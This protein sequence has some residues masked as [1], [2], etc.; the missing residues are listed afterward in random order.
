[1]NPRARQIP[2][3][4]VTASRVP[5]AAAAAVLLVRGRMSG[6]EPWVVLCLLALI[7]AT[8]VFDGILARRLGVAGLFG[9][10]FDPYCDS[11]ARLLTY[12]GLASAGLCPWWLVLLMAVRDVSVAYVRITL[13]LS[14]RKAAA[15][16]SGKLKAIAQGAGGIALA[17]VFAI[18]PLAPRLELRRLSPIIAWLVAAATAWSLVDYSVAALRGKKTPPPVR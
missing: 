1:M 4:V 16:F 8:D 5:L 18:G 13:I 10:L 14:G 3:I 11:I 2:V 7:E 17:A 15:R 9:E 12:F 6:L